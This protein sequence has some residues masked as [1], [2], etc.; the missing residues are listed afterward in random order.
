MPWQER[1][2]NTALWKEGD[3]GFDAG[4]LFRP[5]PMEGHLLRVSNIPYDIHVF[6][7]YNPDSPSPRFGCMPNT[8]RPM[9]SGLILALVGGGGG[10]NNKL[11]VRSPTKPRVSPDVVGRVL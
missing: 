10:S 9:T 5:F 1:V 11:A 7:D 3:T 4:A 6:S 8:A 2:V